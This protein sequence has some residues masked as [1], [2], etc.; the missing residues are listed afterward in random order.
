MHRAREHPA[1][2]ERE[3]KS[4]NILVEAYMTHGA[5]RRLSRP[6][7]TFKKRLLADDDATRHGRARLPAAMHAVHSAFLSGFLE[8][9]GMVFASFK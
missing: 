7:L 6:T 5:W 1:P 9:F 8:S 3:S 4:Q 2:L